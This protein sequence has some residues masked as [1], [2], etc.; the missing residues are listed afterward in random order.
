MKSA[1][2]ILALTLSSSAFANVVVGDSATYDIT[3]GG[4]AHTGTLTIVSISGDTYSTQ[5]SIDGQ[6]TQVS[7][8]SVSQLNQL[9]SIVPNCANYG[10]TPESLATPAGTFNTCHLNAQGSDI[11]VAD[12]PFGVAKLAGP[13]QQMVLKSFIKK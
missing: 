7:T 9:T 13:S 12:V 6:A 3:A 2:L 11:Y 4:Q 5:E 10:G 1:L 8:G